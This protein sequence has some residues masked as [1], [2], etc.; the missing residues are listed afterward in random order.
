MIEPQTRP[1]GH[2]FKVKGERTG[3]MTYR[4]FARTYEEAVEKAVADYNKLFRVSDG[5]VVPT[6][7]PRGSAP[8]GCLNE[9]RPRIRNARRYWSWVPGLPGLGNWTGAA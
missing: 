6:N 5:K 4:L 3:E 2:V 8:M 7:R 9:L 1:H